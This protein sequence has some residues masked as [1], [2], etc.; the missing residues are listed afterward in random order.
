MD[1]G[2]D[3][4][5]C[6]G[7]YSVNI[8]GGDKLCKILVIQLGILLV[9]KYPVEH[10]SVGCGVIDGGVDGACGV[11]CAERAKAKIVI[12]GDHGKLTVLL[13]KIIVVHHCA[14]I[15]VV[16]ADIIVHYEV[17]YHLLNVHDGG[18]IRVLRKLL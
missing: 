9:F 11:A 8:H 1:V 16:V 17:A 3:K 2:R 6:R 10:R 15:A 7:D 5:V 4:L 14:G 12:P 18:H 13:V